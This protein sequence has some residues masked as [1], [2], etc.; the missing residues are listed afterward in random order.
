MKQCHC[1]K[2]L[3]DLDVETN[4]IFRSFIEMTIFLGENQFD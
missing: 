1:D 4:Y 2:I 3:H